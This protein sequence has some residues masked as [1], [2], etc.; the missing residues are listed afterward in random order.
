MGAFILY[1]LMCRIVGQKRYNW[2]KK[3]MGIEKGTQRGIQMGIQTWIQMGIHRI[4]DLA[5]W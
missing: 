2:R 1:Y 5:Q 4:G 3:Q